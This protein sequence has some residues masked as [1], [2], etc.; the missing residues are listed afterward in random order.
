M[1]IC[2]Q[3]AR[4][5]EVF[6]DEKGIKI[7]AEA[8]FQSIDFSMFYPVD[9]GLFAESDEAVSEHFTKL[10][11][12]IDSLGLYVYQT[13]TPFPTYTADE[14]R[15]AVIF[16]AERKALLASKLLGARHAIVHPAIMRENR[17]GSLAAENKAINVDFYSRLI[18]YLDEYD[19]KIAIENMFNY[20]PVK[21]CICPTVCSSSVEMADYVDT[22]NSMCK[23]GDR[24]V[25][26]LDVGHT[27]LSGD[28]PIGD[29]VRTLGGRLKALHIHDNYGVN[30][31]HT[32]PGFGNVNWKEFC[33]ALKEIG[34][35]GDFVF[36]ADNFYAHFDDT[37]LPDASAL[38]YK[39]GRNLV[40][41]YGL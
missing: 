16:E 19:M 20:D 9:K 26:C 15:D 6:G 31:E 12:Y 17:Y 28:K 35:D 3:T 22:M 4:L 38:L 24:F 2:T 40:D 18:P 5:A 41:K 11:R 32:A 39:I 23:N 8:G 7:L 29:M 1:N 30:D 21:K 36:E 13:H 33:T 25:S 10:R 34:Y 27:N 14:A 37:L